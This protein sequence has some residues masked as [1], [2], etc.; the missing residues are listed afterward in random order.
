VDIS[1]KVKTKRVV[2][3]LYKFK[4]R[5]NFKIDVNYSQIK[6]E[7]GDQMFHYL[8]NKSNVAVVKWRSFENY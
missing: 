2:D 6:Y 1:S 7:L 8:Y 5:I 4:I 3:I